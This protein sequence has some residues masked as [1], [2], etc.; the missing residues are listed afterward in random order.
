MPLE[1]KIRTIA[2][3]LYGA[4][5]IQVE[6]KAAAKLAAFAQGGHGHLPV[7]MARPSTRSPPT[8]P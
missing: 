6:S 3:T 2:K 7:C 4:A 8:R 1:D 5:D